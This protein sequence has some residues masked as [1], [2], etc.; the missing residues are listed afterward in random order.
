MIAGSS[1]GTVVG[2]CIGLVFDA[3]F[4]AKG[5]GLLLGA[6]LGLVFGAGIDELRKEQNS[7]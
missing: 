5:M 3:A 2:A 6:A 1:I 4:G 7:N